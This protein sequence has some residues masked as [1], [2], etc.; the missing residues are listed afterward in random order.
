MTHF[1]VQAS[2]LAHNYI[3]DMTASYRPASH[4]EVMS[5]LKSILFW[6]SCL[7]GRGIFLYYKVC[8]LFKKIICCEAVLKNELLVIF[9]LHILLS[10]Y[11]ILAYMCIQ[12]G[13]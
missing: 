5:R 9:E 8:D 12:C 6:G 13:I 4:V 11:C 1:I 10:T 7:P 2:H 3:L